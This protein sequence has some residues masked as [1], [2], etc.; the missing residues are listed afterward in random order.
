MGKTA[1]W[2]Q[3]RLYGRYPALLSGFKTDLARRA[4]SRLAAKISSL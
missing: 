4:L 3:T 1:S 2:R